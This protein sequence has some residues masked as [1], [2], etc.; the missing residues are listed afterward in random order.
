[1]VEGRE[2]EPGR[3]LHKKTA[4]PAELERVL[5]ARGLTLDGV[6]RTFLEEVVGW[7]DPCPTHRTLSTT[8]CECSNRLIVPGCLAAR[9]Q[10]IAQ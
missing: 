7:A 6:E 3:E 1:M 10:L 4:Q 9:G 8:S 2:A 5:S